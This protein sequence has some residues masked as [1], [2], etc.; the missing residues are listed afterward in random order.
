MTIKTGDN[1]KILL[2][3]DRGKV[4]KV[5]QVFPAYQ[6]VVVEG[7][8]MMK[9]HLKKRGKQAGKK[10]EY[11]SP[12]HISNVALVGKDGKTAG[13]IGV[14]TTEKDGKI[15]K[16]RVLRHAGAEEVIE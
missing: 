2:G 10:I 13:R 8:N 4:G 11:A 16:H 6:K 3:K 7:L 5:V 9:K 12:M 1:V 14:S 15:H